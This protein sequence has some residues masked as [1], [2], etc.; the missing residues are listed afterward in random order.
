MRTFLLYWFKAAKRPQPKR[1]FTVEKPRFL[2]SSI[3]KRK[4]FSFLENL[5]WEARMTIS[6]FAVYFPFQ[7]TKGY[8][9]PRPAI[10]HKTSQAKTH[11]K[12]ETAVYCAAF[13]LYS[14]GQFL[15]TSYQ[16]NKVLS[17]IYASSMKSKVLSLHF[18]TL[19][20]ESPLQVIGAGDCARPRKIHD[21]I[22]EGHLAAKLLN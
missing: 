10:Q 3:R 11:K 6:A 4:G 14:Q 13:F 9:L 7:Y 18:D 1:K 2:Y 8:P 5:G 22:H 19:Q 15:Y 20:A 17:V 16:K 12:H 21:A